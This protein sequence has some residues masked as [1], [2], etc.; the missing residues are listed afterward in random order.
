MAA[1]AAVELEVAVVAV[2]AVVAAVWAVVE[3][4][5]VATLAASAPLLLLL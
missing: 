2:D 1:A 4:V 5:L 3:T